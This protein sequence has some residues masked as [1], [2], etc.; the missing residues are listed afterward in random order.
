MRN[1]W[2]DCRKGRVQKSNPYYYFNLLGPLLSYTFV[3]CDSELNQ[4]TED[5]KNWTNKPLGA[6][7]GQI[8]GVLERLES[9]KWLWSHSPQESYWNLLPKPIVLHANTKIATFSRGFKEGPGSYNR[10]L[11][12]FRILSKITW[13]EELG[14]SPLHRK[15][16][17]TDANIQMT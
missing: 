2:E 8:R 16:Q 17:S 15:K 6:H 9:L 10:I 14:T 13:H 5:F 3:I 4:R 1:Y 7:L 11:K 12:I